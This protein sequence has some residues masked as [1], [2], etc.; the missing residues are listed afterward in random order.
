[1]K[2]IIM[3]LILAV[4]SI[5]L[6]DD[7]TVYLIIP[8]ADITDE[9]YVNSHQKD[10]GSARVSIDGVLTLFSYRGTSIPECFVMYK[11]YSKFEMRLI[12]DDPDGRWYRDEE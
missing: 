12:V 10:N 1:M 7:T 8:T 5:S 4:V 6:A 11:S 2:L 9:M 3:I